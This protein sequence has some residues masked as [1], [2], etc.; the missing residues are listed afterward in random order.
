MRFSGK[1]ENWVLGILEPERSKKWQLVQPKGMSLIRKDGIGP[2]L[3]NISWGCSTVYGGLW[4]R[5]QRVRG[6]EPFPRCREQGWAGAF[7]PA[8]TSKRKESYQTLC[9]TTPR[10]KFGSVTP[11]FSWVPSSA[12]QKGCGLGKRYYFRNVCLQH[13]LWVSLYVCSMPRWDDVE[14]SASVFL[15]SVC[16]EIRCT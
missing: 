9:V 11:F 4:D 5:W 8:A 1:L 15:H 13:F 3:N 12:L 2:C 7:S 10:K 6:S 14:P 16:I